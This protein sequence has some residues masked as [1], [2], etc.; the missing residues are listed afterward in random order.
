METVHILTVGSAQNEVEEIKLA[1][2]TGPD[3]LVHYHID[4]ISDYAEA[5]RALV[6][7]S[8]NVV[9][10]DYHF[11][12]LN[13]SGLDLLQRA[14]AGGCTTPVIILSTLPDEEIAWAANDAGAA[15][16]LHKHFDLNERTLKYAI[17]VGVHHFHKLQEMHELLL[18][19]HKQLAELGRRFRRP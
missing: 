10:L 13:L 12:N 2:S 3:A 19:V 4:V 6:R 1:L 5:L 11:T 9:L 7:N 15:G 14:N 16:F 18:D 17:R 8:H